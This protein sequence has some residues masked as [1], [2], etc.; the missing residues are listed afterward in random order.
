MLIIGNFEE[1]EE[2]KSRCGGN[3]EEENCIFK[4]FVECPIDKN[5]LKDVADISTNCIVK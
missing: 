3:C 1:L 2:L 5:Q 4:D